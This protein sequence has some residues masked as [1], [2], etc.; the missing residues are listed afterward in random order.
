MYKR[1]TNYITTEIGSNLASRRS[2]TKTAQ[3]PDGE[4]GHPRRGLKPP[5][6]PPPRSAAPA[7]RAQVVFS[8]YL[9]REHSKEYMRRKAQLLLLLSIFKLCHSLLLLHYIHASN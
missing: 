4:A 8:Q 5:V 9:R 3:F 6:A 1:L 2:P 7:L